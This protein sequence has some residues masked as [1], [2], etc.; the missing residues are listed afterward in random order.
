MLS[1]KYIQE[2]NSQYSKQTN[3]QDDLKTVYWG[4]VISISDENDGGRIKVRID[5]LD[6]NL[7]NENLSDCYPLM[8][9]FFHVYPQ[10]GEVVRIILEDAKYPQKGRYWIGSVISQ[11]QKIG[12]DS[13]YTA[14]STTN[15]AISAPSQ[16]PS[17]L[18]EAQG[19]YPN[20]EDVAILGRC[21]ADITMRVRD[22]ELRAGM[23][24]LNNNLK[25]NQLNPASIRLTFETRETGSTTTPSTVSTNVILADRIA[26]ISHDGE[27]KFKTANFTP[28]DRDKIF[29]DGHPL[30]RGDVI[31][32]ALE[33]L[34]KA[35]I[36]HIHPYSNLPS[37]KSGIIIDLENVDFTRILQRNIVIN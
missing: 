7:I 8:P 27:P 11:P 22:L 31:V 24:E 9:K 13:K 25:F 10:I 23:H 3:I 15:A 4:E 35:I 5:G 17:K 16:A 12:F 18:P 32:E 1:K 33:L 14:L 26:L 28:S 34:R 21:N 37:D 6:N 2:N 36:Q 19:I 20:I 29:S 30:G